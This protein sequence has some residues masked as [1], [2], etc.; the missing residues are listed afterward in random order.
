MPSRKKSES[1]ISSL[2]DSFTN[3]INTSGGS[4]SVLTAIIFIAGGLLSTYVGYSDAALF[5]LVGGLIAILIGILIIIKA[6]TQKQKKRLQKKESRAHNR[7][8]RSSE[9]D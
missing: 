4:T 9:R 6:R 1:L 7:F 5:N 3:S 8:M 2:F